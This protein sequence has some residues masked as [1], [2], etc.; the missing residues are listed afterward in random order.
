MGC[1]FPRQNTSF[2]FTPFVFAQLSSTL[3]RWYLHNHTLFKSSTPLPLANLPFW[4]PTQVLHSACHNMTSYICC[5]QVYS[6]CEPGKKLENHTESFLAY[7][8]LH[9]LMHSRVPDTQKTVDKEGTKTGEEGKEVRDVKCSRNKT[10]LLHSTG[11]MDWGMSPQNS[12][13]EG[14]PHILK[15]VNGLEEK[16]LVTD[17]RRWLTWLVDCCFF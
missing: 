4:A 17:D 12:H 6:V 14:L 1:S 9:F 16:S 11:V 7:W 8:C 13:G 3:S 2:L 15:R 5:I 10:S